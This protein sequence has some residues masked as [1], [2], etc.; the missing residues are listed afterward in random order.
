MQMH[1]RREFLTIAAAGLAAPKPRPQAKPLRLMAV[2]QSLVKQPLDDQ[3]NPGY[4]TIGARLAQADVRFSNLEVAIRGALSRDARPT[5]TPG[6]IAEPA[7]LDSLKALSFNVLSLANN[8]AD[9]LGELGLFSTIEE[10]QRRGFAHAG[11][12]RTLAEATAPGYLD[13][14]RG[15]VALVAMASSGL[16]SNSFA[17]PTRPGVNHLAQLNGIVNPEDS[18]RVLAAIREAASKVTWVIVYHHDHYWAPNWQDTPEWKKEWCRACIDAGAS[19]FVSHGVP[20]LHGIELYKKRP[21]FY[22]LGNFIF[23]SVTDADGNIPTLA[24]QTECWQS[25]IAD[26]EFD[27]PE[28]RSL[29]LNPI[30]MKSDVGLG[31]EN[32]QLRGNPRLLHG[33]PRL[34][35]GSEATEILGRLRTLSSPLGTE[36]AISGSS[37]SVRV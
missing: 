17:T 27:G 31:E 19:V 30:V 21:I 9:D 18:L 12:G 24:R 20:I 5:R 6:A 11:T 14:P 23:H 16:S 25:V 36:I 1:S 15:K 7:V 32:Y 22:G 2:G 34:A 3:Q 13:T 33:N 29:R 4:A 35:E 37:A 8:H 10:V 26:C 28:L